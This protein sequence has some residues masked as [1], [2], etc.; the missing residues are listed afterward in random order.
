MYFC[1]GKNEEGRLNGRVCVV[2][3]PIASL[4]A[5]NDSYDCSLKPFVAWG[6]THTHTCA[7]KIVP[8]SGPPPA[9]PTVSLNCVL[10]LS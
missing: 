4:F 5:A 2:K 6:W 8:M 1:R 3:L 9:S 7:H 10:R